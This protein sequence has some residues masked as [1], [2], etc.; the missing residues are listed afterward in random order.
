MALGNRT[1]TWR[2]DG[3]KIYR[4]QKPLLVRWLKVSRISGA[5]QMRG[6]L[7]KGEWKT[8]TATDLTKEAQK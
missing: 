8:S 5:G 3:S 2:A 7:K 4:G 6:E 1:Q